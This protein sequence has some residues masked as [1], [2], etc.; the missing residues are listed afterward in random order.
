MSLVYIFLSEE[1]LLSQRAYQSQGKWLSLN[2]LLALC[3]YLIFYVTS[4]TLFVSEQGG[5]EGGETL[6]SSP[7][8]ATVAKALLRAGAR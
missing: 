6:E 7:F 1:F 5:K 8:Y 2:F 4:D 3:D